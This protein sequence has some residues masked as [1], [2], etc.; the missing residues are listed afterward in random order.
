[1]LVYVIMCML[2]TELH[3]APLERNNLH[4][5]S[6]I[7]HIIGLSYMY[8]AVGR[9]IYALVCYRRS[10]DRGYKNN[11]VRPF[12]VG[13]LWGVIII[14]VFVGWHIWAPQYTEPLY[15]A[16]LFCVMWG[17]VGIIDHSIYGRYG[18]KYNLTLFD[19]RGD[20]LCSSP[21]TPRVT[22]KAD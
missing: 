15:G 11:L 5:F 10:L 6:V 19:G 17:W 21:N 16:A 12:L 22:P 13:A 8:A 9:P 2:F 20:I 14:G 18:K 3:P 4:A 7:M 1:M